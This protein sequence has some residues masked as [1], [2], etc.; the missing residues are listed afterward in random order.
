VLAGRLQS[1]PHWG[2][3]GDRGYLEELIRCVPLH[4]IG[5]IAIPD[6]VLNK[7][8]PLE[9]DEWKL[10]YAHPVVG[11]TMLDALA[12][13]HGDSLTFLSIARSIVRHHHERW[14][15]AGYPDRL[16]GKKI[17]HAARLVAIADVYDSLRRERPHRPG[18]T[19]SESTDA[20]LSTKGHFDPAVLEAF[21]A[22][23]E[24]FEEIYAT[25]PN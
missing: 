3:L 13:E 11:S 20:I 8:G 22:S 14:D 17:P 19:H 6:A 2:I 5:K 4:D 21:T 9:A 1:H 23:V 16:L 18:L 12:R 25:I 10:V 7:P 15:G 24:Q